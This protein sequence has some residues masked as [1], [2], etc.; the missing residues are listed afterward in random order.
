MSIHVTAGDPDTRTSVHRIG[1]SGGDK[2]GI[3]MSRISAVLLAKHADE[4]GGERRPRVG[5]PRWTTIKI[6]LESYDARIQMAFSFP[7][8][9][10]K[11]CGTVFRIFSITT[12][13][14]KTVEAGGGAQRDH[15]PRLT[16]I[17]RPARVR[18]RLS[19][20]ARAQRGA[21]AT[22]HSQRSVARNFR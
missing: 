9:D 17:P 18:L 14:W 10:R 2:K 7:V 16:S 11:A 15:S 13:R 19:E 4:G 3:N 8:K 5:R 22:P 21:V 1:Q 20:H 12:S 6:R